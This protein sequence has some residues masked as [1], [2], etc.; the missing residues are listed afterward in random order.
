LHARDPPQDPEAVSA[1]ADDVS[2]LF[3]GIIAVQREQLER[4][5]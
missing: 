4:A 5:Y 3:R 2:G 1:L